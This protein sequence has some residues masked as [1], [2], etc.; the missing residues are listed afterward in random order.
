MAHLKKKAEKHSIWM[1]DKDEKEK[2]DYDEQ[3]E[4]TE[5]EDDLDSNAGYDNTDE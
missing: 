4:E 3:E 1:D 2:I 5:E